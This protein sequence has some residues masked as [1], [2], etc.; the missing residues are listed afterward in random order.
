VPDSKSIDSWNEWGKH[1]LAELERLSSS[2][3]VIDERVQRIDARVRGIEIEIG[4]LKVKSGVWG[5]V[6]GMIPVLIGI[7]L[8]IL[9][10]L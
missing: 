5:L 7:T 8:M 9:S 6:G 3:V 1:V 2:C 4:M 10:K